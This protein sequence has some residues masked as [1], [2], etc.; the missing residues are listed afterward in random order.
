M[1]WFNLLKRKKEY[2]PSRPIARGGGSKKIRNTPIV[3]SLRRD[4]I[5]ISGVGARTHGWASRPKTR[6]GARREDEEIM[7]KPELDDL[8][9]EDE[10]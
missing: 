7:L 2:K 5:G 10:E 4:Y 1:N 6:T 9:N 3:D 8:E